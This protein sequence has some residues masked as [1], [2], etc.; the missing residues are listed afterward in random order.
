MLLSRGGFRFCVV[1]T[2]FLA[3]FLFFR[4]SGEI[5]TRRIIVFL[6]SG[7][8]I[9]SLVFQGKY[10]Q[11]HY[12]P[13]I[14]PLLILSFGAVSLIIKK[15]FRF[16]R[17]VKYSFIMAALALST[18]IFVSS[19][20][21]YVKPAL[22]LTTGKIPLKEHYKNFDKYTIADF[23]L[24]AG[25]DTAAFISGNTNPNDEI[26]IWGFEPLVYV[27]SDR[28]CTSRFIYNVPLFWPWAVDEY[29]TE[30]MTAMHK[31]KPKYFLV[32]RNDELPWVTGVYDDS[33]KA[34]KKYSELNLFVEQHYVYDREIEDFV[35][36]RRIN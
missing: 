20:L 23:S 9:L 36:Y 18:Y 11:Y 8:G 22:S 16:V 32:L 3:L 29:K 17:L 25:M 24:S 30:F 34:L 10:F 1:L 19:Y 4:L 31:K 28:K 21:S 27:L 7:A 13:L 33:E 6:W 35:I 5:T 26:Y 12:L 14:A 2:L 15:R